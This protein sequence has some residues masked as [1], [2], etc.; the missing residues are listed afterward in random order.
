MLYKKIHRQ[1][2]KEFWVG[3][4]FKYKCNIYEVTGGP[5]IIRMTAYEYI[6]VDL[7]YEEL[8]HIICISTRRMRFRNTITLLN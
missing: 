6:V 1:Y 2:V 4:K 8:L 7:E 3:R 5:R